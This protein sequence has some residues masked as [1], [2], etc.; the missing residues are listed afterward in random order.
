MKVILITGATDGIGFQ[1]ARKLVEAGHH[2]LVH[3]RSDTKL[4][5]VLAE[6][7]A[8]GRVEAYQADLSDFSQIQ[9]MV[10][11]ITA[12]HDRLDVLINNAGVFKTPT[13]RTK[14]GLDVRFAVNTI[15]PY[16]L[17]K[18]LL[19]KIPH[20]G[21]VVNLSSAAQMPVNHHSLRGEGKMEAYDAYSQSK[22][23][24]AQWS[25]ALSKKVPQLVVSINPGS[26][27]ATKMVREGYGIVGKDST[28][29][30]DIICTA[31]LSKEF[32]HHSGDYFD[33]D[34][35]E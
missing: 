28:I 15:A 29:G 22:L 9:A 24:I 12:K 27:L 18:R 17:T 34:G 26:L 35:K 3:G 14:D 13:D 33:N 23:A 16:L 11:E 30:S 2:V 19:P 32:E 5:Q 1:A 10:H 4:H 8:I 6:L 21:R 31:A 20:D 25:H 7:S